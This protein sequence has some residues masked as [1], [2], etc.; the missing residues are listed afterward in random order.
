MSLQI[1]ASKLC[2][3]LQFHGFILKVPMCDIIK[4]K[5]FNN[6]AKRYKSAIYIINFPLF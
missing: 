3:L 2:T 6:A 5:A 1:T 4:R